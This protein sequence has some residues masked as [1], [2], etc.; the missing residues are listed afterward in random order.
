MKKFIKKVI[1]FSVTILITFFVGEMTVS[2]GL[3]QTQF[4]DYAEW[5]DLYSGNINAD[6]IING[7]SKAWVNVSPQI[8]DSFLGLN[9]YNLGIDGH[10]FLLQHR[11][12]MT[13][14]NFNTPP[15]IV[16]QVVGTETLEKR[17]DLYN[18]TQF[19]PYLNDSLIRNTTREYEGFGFADYN[20]PFY[21]YLGHEPVI[22]VGLLEYWGI[23][24][25]KNDRFKGYKGQEKEWDNSFENFK[26]LFPNGKPASVHP[27]TLQLF[28]QYLQYCKDNGIEVHLAFSPEYYQAQPYT[29]NRDEINEI[30]KRFAKRYN[31]TYKD[32]SI[33]TLNFN[34]SF[35]YNSQ[36]LN[37]LGSEI[38]S[39]MLA[40]DLYQLYELKE[41]N[42]NAIVK[43]S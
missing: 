32:Y 27:E 19:L 5:T 26:A 21:R 22:T 7:S 2:E 25:F 43:G 15:R 38:F 3:R 28:D 41:K 31:F 33:D 1:V 42:K 13:Y 36:H 35:F 37:K 8:L 18:Y 17:K 16:V 14:L 11:K 23:K 10:N 24:H 9:S 4:G 39:K 6:V 20:I 34:K 30:Y 40:N 12:F 29:T